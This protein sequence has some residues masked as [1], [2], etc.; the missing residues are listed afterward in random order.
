[1]QVQSFNPKRKRFLSYKR[2]N[3]FSFVITC[4]KLL[5]HGNIHI[6]KTHCAQY[7]VTEGIL[8]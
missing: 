1:L 5:Q 7:A 8:R 4:S 6:V 3:T 2:H